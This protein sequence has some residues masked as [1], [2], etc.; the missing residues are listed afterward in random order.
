MGKKRKD[1]I[2]PDLEVDDAA[3]G[4][5]SSVPDHSTTNSAKKRKK[6]DRGQENVPS[7]EAEQGNEPNSDRIVNKENQELKENDVGGTV[8][9]EVYQAS[10][11]EGSNSASSDQNGTLPPPPS[12]KLQSDSFFSEVTFDELCICDPLK[13][14][15]QSM[16]MKTLTEIQV[17]DCRETD[18]Q[19]KQAKWT[20]TATRRSSSIL[21]E[22]PF[23]SFHCVVFSAFLV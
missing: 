14:A 3:S 7:L 18:L 13:K 2:V 23:A 21:I 4:V 12:S 20:K 6:I 8:D 11:S 9:K 22:S 17:R 16:N 10:Y 5:K 19:K 1:R 15:L